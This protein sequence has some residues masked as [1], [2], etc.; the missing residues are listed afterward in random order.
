[1]LVDGPYNLIIDAMVLNNQ[2]FWID[3]IQYVP[4]AS[5]P[6]DQAAIVVD[7]Q[8]PQLQFSQGWLEEDFSQVTLVSGA[9]ASYNFVSMYIVMC[10]L[11]FG[12][13]FLGL[14]LTFS[15]PRP[16]PLALVWPRLGLA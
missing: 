4:S 9:M 1:M 8:D 13:A 7:H 15:R 11:G 12:L 6:L 3:Y 2:T 5:V 16:N 14:G 10:W